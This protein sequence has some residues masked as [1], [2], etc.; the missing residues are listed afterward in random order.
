MIDDLDVVV[1]K[2]DCIC[3]SKEVKAGRK[4]TIMQMFGEDWASVELTDSNGGMYSVT[5]PTENLEISK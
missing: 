5:M 3:E 4:G 1:V 2:E